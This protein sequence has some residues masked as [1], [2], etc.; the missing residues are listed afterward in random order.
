M[1]MLVVIIRY[2]E[3]SP[4][5][6]DSIICDMV[7]CFSAWQEVDED[8]FEYSVQAREEDINCIKGILSAY[9][10]R[11]WGYQAPWTQSMVATWQG[12]RKFFKKSVD[13]LLRV[14]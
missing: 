9:V 10:Q 1:R 14:C 12:F 3:I 11:K 4:A 2:E 6:L 8:C 13:K 7:P 5:V